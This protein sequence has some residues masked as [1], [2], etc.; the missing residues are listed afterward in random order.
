M[1]VLYSGRRLHMTELLEAL[2]VKADEQRIDPAN[3]LSDPCLVTS[4][5][6]G[7]VEVRRGYVQLVHSSIQ[8][9]FLS[10]GEEVWGPLDFH[11]KKNP[12]NVEISQ[13][14]LTYLMHD[15][16][17]IGDAVSLVEL[18]DGFRSHPL[19]LYAAAFWA[20][21]IRGAAEK[22]LHKLLL[23]MLENSR[24][25]SS[26]MR[27]LFG[28]SFL[29][30]GR[31][32]G[33][34]KD[35]NPLHI[36]V[37][38]NLEYTVRQLPHAKL[39]KYLN[40]EDCDGETPC[41]IATRENMSSMAEFLIKAGAKIHHRSPRGLDSLHR[42]CMH[43][44]I[45]IVELLLSAGANPNVQTKEGT[46]IP[47]FGSSNGQQ[48]EEVRLLS[49]AGW[50]A[51]HASAFH[52]RTAVVRML[53]EAKVDVNALS[54]AGWTAVYEA[55][56]NNHPRIVEQLI[57]AGADVDLRRENGESVY[58][59]A[60]RLGRFTCLRLLL[61]KVSDVKLPIEGDTML[62][63]AA[64][65]GNLSIV[66]CLIA[67]GADVDAQTEDKASF[68]LYSAAWKGHYEVC[69]RLVK[70]GANVNITKT[71]HYATALLAAVQ[72][73]QK[74]IVTLLLESGADPKLQLDNW[75]ILHCASQSKSLEM[76]EIALSTK[77]DINGQGSVGRTPLQNACEEGCDVEI[78]QKL[79]ENGADPHVIT[80]EHQRSCLYYAALNGHEHIVE[81]LLGKGVDVNAQ[82]DT[83]DTALTLACVNGYLPIVR[84]LL[85]AGCDVNLQNS[86][87]RPG[88][89][90][91]ASC[92]HSAI[93]ELLVKG[94]A[95]LEISDVYQFTA[96]SLA[97]GNNRWAI[98]HM[99]VE[100]GAA[101]DG[102]GPGG[103]SAAMSAA[104]SGYRDVLQ[105]L[106]EK[107][108]DVRL[109]SDDGNTAMHL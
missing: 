76:M 99:L 17:D 20:D 44:N 30:N 94:G 11:I 85:K 81:W 90:D 52:G 15:D 31:F 36:L 7:L 82:N 74:K 56:S 24:P 61:T 98:S 84:H 69:E 64:L 77:P 106:I 2:A 89:L 78:L 33:F 12:S 95:D 71:N 86:K 42:A 70:A 34:P 68:P 27:I 102:R 49:H 73:N 10:E 26:P 91:A 50:N 48:D 25:N 87:K 41:L 46:T 3:R 43:G 97:A 6:A 53:I 54:E 19:A 51:L 92:G 55:I 16:L 60:I 103:W 22:A 63:K 93:V 96:L 72:N 59:L 107:G 32:E 109:A 83:E 35:S 67:R 14:L 58:A 62:N 21:H 18:S 65:S 47:S 57:M 13:T 4:V 79:F 28:N 29:Q 108:A 5:C 105:Y 37:S 100:A 66:D 104:R 38:N 40:G 101:I 39:K 75:S 1:W 80:G 8:D 9:F 88:L 45:K 23:E